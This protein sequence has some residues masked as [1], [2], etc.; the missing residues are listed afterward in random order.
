MRQLGLPKSAQEVPESDAKCSQPKWRGAAMNAEGHLRMVLISNLI[1]LRH[2]PLEARRE[3]GEHRVE[4]MISKEPHRPGDSKSRVGHHP[5][6][7]TFPNLQIYKP[8]QG[9]GENQSD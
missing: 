4:I 7:K 8:D 6:I 5:S 3:K 2:A 1:A 9:G